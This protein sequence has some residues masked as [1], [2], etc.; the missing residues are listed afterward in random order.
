MM[1]RADV[2][3]YL[4]REL[5]YKS[6]LEIGVERGDTFNLIKCDL[7]YCVDPDDRYMNPTFRM[8][9]NEFFRLHRMRTYDLIYIDG[10][11]RAEQVYIDTAKSLNA[12]NPGGCIVLHDVNPPN[13]AYTR[14]GLC[15]DAYKALYMLMQEDND[16]GIYAMEMPKDQGNGIG[17]I[18][19]GFKWP[20][21]RR[22]RTRQDPQ[23]RDFLEAKDH[24]GAWISEGQF[25]MLVDQQQSK[26]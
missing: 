4:I 6:Y 25:K 18:F 13:E 14:E 1:T 24:S 26:R 8:T 20:P 19:N 9:S 22:L 16:L 21:Y 10:D 15:F 23:W 2:M 12:L 3:N 17:L 7:K 5:A 11:H